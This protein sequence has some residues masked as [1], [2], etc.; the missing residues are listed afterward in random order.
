MSNEGCT[1][2]AEHLELK[3]YVFGQFTVIGTSYYKPPN[4]T[5][6]GMLASLTISPL[7]R[8]QMMKVH[9]LSSGVKLA[10]SQVTVARLATVEHVPQSVAW[11]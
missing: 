10:M 6:K 11:I 5:V 7:T 4:I 9:N 3:M 8:A 2:L 1:Q